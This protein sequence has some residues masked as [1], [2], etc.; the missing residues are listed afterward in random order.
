MTIPVPMSSLTKK[1]GSTGRDSPFSGFLHV[2]KRSSCA[3]TSLTTFMST[4]LLSPA[5]AALAR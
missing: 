2:F 4:W 1:P 5:A 3:L